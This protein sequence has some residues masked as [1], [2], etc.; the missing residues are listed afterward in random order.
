MPEQIT[1]YKIFLGSPSDLSEERIAIEEV[2]SELNISQG[3]RNGYTLELLKWE[4][5]STPGIAQN[6]IQEL[7]NTELG[8]EYDIFIGMLWTKFGTPTIDAESGTEEEFNLA[9][10]RHLDD[11]N[12]IKVLFYFKNT[13]KPLNEINPEQLLKVQNFKKSL[14][15][16][17]VLY[18]EFESVEIFKKY[19]RMHI[20]V[21]IDEL[22]AP[23]TYTEVTTSDTLDVIN[24]ELGLIDYQ[25]NFDNYLKLTNH[26]IR[27]IIESTE[28]ITNEISQSA[29]DLTHF[30]E[31]PERNRHALRNLLHRTANSMEDFSSRLK[32]ESA[33]FYSNYEDAMD[34]GIGL[35]NVLADF[36]SIDSLNDLEITQEA[37]FSMK[38]SINNGISGMTEFYSSISTLPRIEQKF[39]KARQKMSNEL[40]GMITKLGD[41]LKL[42]EE[43]SKQIGD[44]VDQM[45][46]K[47]N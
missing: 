14:Q 13:P 1:K 37:I 24:D 38:G 30:M 2:I 18:A 26:S 20:P 40:N 8:Q 17:K 35:M 25:E 33:L 3:N 43:F 12:L 21:K 44:R 47:L 46:L 15:N 28:W 6:H 41:A 5:H 9:Y 4:T 36:T 39:N 34:S 22:R 11:A 10:S 16:K 19:L 45:K 29:N 7:I 27:S 23:R 32:S 42:T 31:V